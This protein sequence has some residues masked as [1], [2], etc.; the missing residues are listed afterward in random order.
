[1]GDELGDIVMFY[2]HGVVENSVPHLHI[3][4]GFTFSVHYRLANAPFTNCKSWCASAGSNLMA[5]TYCRSSQNT[6]KT[7]LH[8]NRY[9][10]L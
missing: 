3:V 4:I 9:Y 10:N 8:R 1:M 7:L 5:D 2:D 6:L